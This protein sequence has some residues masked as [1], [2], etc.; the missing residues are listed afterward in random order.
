MGR[1]EG[2]AQVYVVY[3]VE[4]KCKFCK[5]ARHCSFAFVSVIGH[6][7]CM[8]RSFHHIH[9]IIGRY[10][11]PKRMVARVSLFESNRESSKFLKLDRL[12][13]RTDR[14][15]PLRLGMVILLGLRLFEQPVL[16]LYNRYD[17]K[18]P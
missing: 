10:Y 14:L 4:M 7:P 1:V 5:C 9:M 11:K 3:V 15:P 18:E 13:S 12:L 6:F 8:D 2:V 16:T 17:E